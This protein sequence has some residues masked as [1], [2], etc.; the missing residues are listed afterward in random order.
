MARNQSKIAARMIL[1]PGLVAI[2][3]YQPAYRASEFA[4]GPEHAVPAPPRII[5][6]WLA[7][8]DNAQ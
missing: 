8:F 7:L 5:A 6:G 4:V 1:E 3:G 2:I